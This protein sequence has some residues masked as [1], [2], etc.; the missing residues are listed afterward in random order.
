M[1]ALQMTAALFLLFVVSAGAASKNTYA[2]VDSLVG[3]AQ[4]QRSGTQTWQKTFKGDKL[5]N[6]D[7]IRV[8][9]KSYVQLGWPDQSASYMQQN[10]QV[11][12]AFYENDAS[13]VISRHITVMY[14]AVFFVI[15]EILPKSLIK[16]YDTKIYTPTSVVSLR[17]TSFSVEVDTASKA[18]TVRVINGTVQVRN[19]LKNSSIFVSASFQSVV[20]ITQDPIGP[21]ALLDREIDSLKSWVPVYVME[22]EMAAQ[23]VKGHRDREIMSSD[24]KDKILIIPFENTSKY[25]GA[26]KI[27]PGFAKIF[28]DQ[29]QHGHIAAEIYDSLDKDPL[30]L[31][32]RKMAR[33][34]VS[35]E[36]KD[37]DIVQHAE[38][39]ATADEYREYYIA[40]VRISI[41]IINVPEKKVVFENEY[42]AEKR[43]ANSKENSW[44]RISKLSF[45]LAD[46]QFVKS[47]LGT[48]VSQV[49]ETATEKLNSIIKYE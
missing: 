12:L 26:W 20:P 48:A 36:I 39:A 47:L 42:V 30:T 19:I 7:V 27:S 6:N 13:N 14:G 9:D 22:R 21:K 16:Q 5:F 18:S 24:C 44:Q 28:S 8:L 1:K 41:Q 23:L 17:G 40:T 35:G 34:V 4:V 2:T 49:V 43:G 10:S 29:L 38:I 31:G 32:Q 37:F 45:S 11:L 46:Q 15:K 33:Y 25:T 3:N